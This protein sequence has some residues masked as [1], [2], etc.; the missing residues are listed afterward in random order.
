MKHKKILYSLSLIFLLAFSSCLKPR[1]ELDDTLWGDNATVIAAVL[2]KYDEIKQQLGYNEV[3]TGYETKGVTATTTIDKANST[4]TMIVA[5]TTPATDLTKI[6]IRISHYAKKI[7]PVNGAPAAGIIA[8]FSKGPF[9][10]RLFSADGT[11]RD[12]TI[13]ISV[14]P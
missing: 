8:D 1:V 3:V 5:K 12:W 13:N 11:T 14:A 10:Y 4:I 6:G 2:F 7:E 9:V